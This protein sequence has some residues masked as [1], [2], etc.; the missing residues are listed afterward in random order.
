M[1]SL[2]DV[3][4]IWDGLPLFE[5]SSDEDAS[6][7]SFTFR[8]FHRAVDDVIGVYNDLAPPDNED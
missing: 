5:T 3:I 2:T 4:S 8:D 7:N 6:E 1:I